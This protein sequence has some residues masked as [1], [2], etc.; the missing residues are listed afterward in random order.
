MALIKRYASLLLTVGFLA[1]FI[2]YGLTHREIFHDLT[3]IAVW[4]LVLIVVGK[5]INV[6]TTG[7]FTK[8]TVEAFTDTLSQAESFVVAVLT[9]IGNFFGPLFGGLG[10]RAVYLKKYHQLPY[11]KFTSTLIG[12]YLL[13][14]LFNSLLAVVGLLLL[15]HGNHTNFL[16]LVFGGWFILFLGLMFVKLPQRQ[17]F[18]WLERNKLGK[19]LVKTTYDIEDG[20]QVM[21]HKRKLLVQMIVLA[22][23]NLVALYFVNYVEFVALDIHVTAA[24]MMLYTAIV[25]ASLLISLTP[26]AVGLRETLLI[27]LG[28]TL[29]ITNEQIVQVAI[30]DRGI[31]FV[32]LGALFLLTRHSKFRRNMEDAGKEIQANPQPK[33][34]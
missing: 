4:A 25:Q 13:M 5:L 22:I 17:K 34:V 31:Y 6:W 16:L 14:L 1:L 29:G 10:I 19:L 11:S 2:W 9:A 24:A 32:M 33:E 26:G 15:P 30:L 3:N 7:L 28:G 23:V 21:L 12:Y 18:A 8:W 20:W 27:V